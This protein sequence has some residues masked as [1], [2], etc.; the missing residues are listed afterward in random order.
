MISL[1]LLNILRFAPSSI[2]YGS[3]LAAEPSVTI[4]KTSEKIVIDGS[5]D[6]DVWKQATPITNL[7]R[8]I[9]TDGG[10]PAGTTEIRMIQDEDTLYFSMIVRDSETPIQARVSPREDVNDDDQ[11]GIYIDT[12]GDGRTGYIF[13]INPIGI[14]QDMRYS[15]GNWM[16]K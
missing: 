16:M 13:Y 4:I 11:I 1:F 5:L 8:F 2:F 6:E 10:A 3:A 14:Q 9:P 7:I 15:N 12:I